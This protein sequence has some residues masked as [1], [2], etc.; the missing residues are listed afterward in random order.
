MPKISGREVL[1]ET[2]EKTQTKLLVVAG[3][4]I[5]AKAYQV[6]VQELKV[7]GMEFP[8]AIFDVS[9]I[10]TLS[11]LYYSYVIK[12]GADLIGFRTWYSET[13]IWTTFGTRTKLDKHFIGE[14]VKALKAFAELERASLTAEKF[15]QLPQDKKDLYESFHLNV[16][17]YGT[18]LQHAGTKFKLISSCGHFYVWVQGFIFPTI[19]AATGLYLLVKYGT[20]TGPARI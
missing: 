8:A 6:P 20:V 18:R 10:A 5:L 14:G 7:A 19:L 2:T 9:M 16:E 1:S 11:W 4:A 17:L 3:V 12:W 15:N 13:T